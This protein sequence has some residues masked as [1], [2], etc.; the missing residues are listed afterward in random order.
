MLSLSTYAVKIFSVFWAL[1][2]AD[3]QMNIVELVVSFN[4]FF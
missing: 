4:I 3:Q 1:L 2:L